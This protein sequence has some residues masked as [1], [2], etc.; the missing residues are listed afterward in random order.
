MTLAQ[1]ARST[2]GIVNTAMAL[3]YAVAIEQEGQRWRGDRMGTELALRLARAYNVETAFMERLLDEEWTWRMCARDGNPQTLP[4]MSQYIYRPLPEAAHNLFSSGFVVLDCE[5]TGKDPHAD[6][7]IC[8]ITVLDVDGVVLLNSLVNPGVHIPDELT[9]NVHGISDEMVKD[10]PT[11]R[12]IYPE[13]A[14]A[15]QGQTVVIYNANYDAFLLDR[16]I[17]EQ[18]LDMPNFEPWCLMEA[19]KQH[20]KAERWVKLTMACEREG[21]ELDMEAHRSLADTISTWRLL[22]KLALQREE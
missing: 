7:Q 12:E 20:I 19:Y 13:I 3:K 14:R 2:W 4:R 22:Q 9:V 5:T 10:A 6:T 1:V 21:V 16:L 18:N 17:I 11:F 8:E 15:I